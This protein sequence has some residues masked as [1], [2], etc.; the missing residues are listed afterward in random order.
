MSNSPALWL[1]ASQVYYPYFYNLPA[2][3][4][5]VPICIHTLRPF[6]RPGKR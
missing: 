2:V 1:S 6:S 5:H 4:P 3:W